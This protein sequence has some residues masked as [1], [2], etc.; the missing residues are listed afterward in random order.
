[1]DTRNLAVGGDPRSAQVMTDTIREIR[2]PGGPVDGRSGIE[3]V[4]VWT[5]FDVVSRAGIA[6]WSKKRVIA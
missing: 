2:T 1:M 5:G 6:L 4:R 3:V